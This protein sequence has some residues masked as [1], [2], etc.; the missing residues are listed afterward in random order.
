MDAHE[1]RLAALTIILAMM[2]GMIFAQSSAVTASVDSSASS[3]ATIRTSGSV[4]TQGSGASGSAVSI[5]RTGDNSSTQ[6]QVSTSQSTSVGVGSGES[7]IVQEHFARLSV[8]L[9]DLVGLGFD[10]G[11]VA[12]ARLELA[13]EKQAW[14]DAATDAQRQTVADHMTAY[15]SALRDR[16]RAS[17]VPYDFD[18]AFGASSAGGSSVISSSA[19]SGSTPPSG[20]TDASATLNPVFNTLDDASVQTEGQPQGASGFADVLIQ[21]TAGMVT[22]VGAMLSAWVGTFLA[23]FYSKT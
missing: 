12:D 21:G 1:R 3:D 19:G 9:D 10:P 17:G 20:A 23:L 22:S 5:V 6:T 11:I 16:V 7:E 4:T 18:V 15:W 13:E 14:S 8:I 2:A